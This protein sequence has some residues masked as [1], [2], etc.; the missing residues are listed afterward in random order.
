MCDDEG[1]SGEVDSRRPQKAGQDRA[2]N[3]YSAPVNST[4]LNK[5][6][7]FFIFSSLGISPMGPDHLRNFASKFAFLQL[8]TAFANI[9]KSI[10]VS[11]V[12]KES[13]MSEV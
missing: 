9:Y 8:R 10:Q 7:L 6:L 5:E 1:L 12:H 4:E 2:Q 11:L 13:H 3:P